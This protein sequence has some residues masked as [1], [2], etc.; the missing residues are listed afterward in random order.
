M[1]KKG[2]VSLGVLVLFIGLLAAPSLN[3]AEKRVNK[4]DPSTLL[5]KPVALLSSFLPIFGSIYDTNETVKN[6][7]NA[8]KGKIKPTGDVLVG[9]PIG[10]D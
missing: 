9:R 4:F 8:S 10:D 5:K 6:T 7:P 1:N 3:S 2:F